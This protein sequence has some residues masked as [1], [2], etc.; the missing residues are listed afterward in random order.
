MPGKW[1]QYNQI[2]QGIA[3]LLHP[4]A[5]VVV[6]DLEKQQIAILVN[7]FSKSKIGHEASQ[8]NID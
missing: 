6:H 4:Y 5:E 3:T 1:D 2:A 8:P 7:N